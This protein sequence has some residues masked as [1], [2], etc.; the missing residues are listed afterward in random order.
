MLIIRIKESTFLPKTSKYDLLLD[1]KKFAKE[2]LF[3]FNC[4]NRNQFFTTIT[5]QPERFHRTVIQILAQKIQQKMSSA[6]DLMI[7]IKLAS[8]LNDGSFELNSM[9]NK[10]IIK[11]ML[12]S[13]SISSL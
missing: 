4:G 5:F 13:T 1:A 10:V 9:D 11:T 8:Y 7:F 6:N 3:A 2:N 12:D